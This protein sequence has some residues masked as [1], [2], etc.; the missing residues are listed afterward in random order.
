MHDR[1][2]NPLNVGDQVTLLAEIVSLNGTEN[3]CNVSIKSVYPRRPDGLFETIS[4]INTGV[5][6]KVGSTP[7]DDATPK[8]VE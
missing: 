2:G 1:N 6:D 7:P 4:S 3:Y 8:T 5:L